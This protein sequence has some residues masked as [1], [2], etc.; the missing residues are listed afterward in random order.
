MSVP[1]PLSARTRWAVAALLAVLWFALLGDRPLRDPDEGRYAEI[2][3]E[4]VATGDWLTPR[5]NG[6]K[7]FEKPPL[8]YW[9]TATLFSAF[10]ES[11]LTA[12]LWVGLVGFF[13]GLWTWL[14]GARLFGGRAGLLSCLV[15]LSSSLYMLSGHFVTLDMTLSVFMAV[16]FGA[17]LVAQADRA[18][19]AGV[20]RW[21][22]AGW[23]ALGLAVL[24]KGPVGI[25]LPGVAVLLYMVWQ[26]DW[27]LLRHLH[28][29]VGVPV[30]LAIAAPWFVAVSIAN[31]EFPWFFFVHEH[32]ERFTTDVH[33]RDEPAYF[34]FVVLLLG[35]L[36]W[37]AA[38]TRE[39]LRP[40]FGWRGGA[41]RGFDAQRLLWVYAVVVVAFFSF[42]HSKLP[43]YILPAMP[44]LALL[45]GKGLADRSSFRAEGATLGLLAG[46][47]LLAAATANWWPPT[48]G[49]IPDEMIRGLAPWLVGAGLVLAVGAVVTGVARSSLKAGLAVAVSAMLAMQVLSR[50]FQPIQA[51]FSNEQLAN[52][53][54]PVLAPDTPV[55]NVG[56]FEPSLAFYLGRT[57]TQ[58]KQEGELSFGIG[59]EPGTFV[60]DLDEFV[61]RWRATA[62]GVAVLHVDYIEKLDLA[63]LGGRSIYRDPNR[64]VIARP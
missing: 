19:G 15:L 49:R 35:A 60:A 57:V 10:G 30:F 7:Y 28:L 55:Y 62:R 25:V 46:L 45:A 43:T 42:S 59:E 38:I 63:A 56:H 36:P 48:V 1:M 34:F 20:R 4:M 11:N 5:L 33:H 14:V 52:A 61:A 2:A 54:L 22:L 53:V 39:L 31:P 51:P 16:A 17:L 24:A 37:L 13:G 50:G 32:L 12:R 41:G 64:V 27:V 47:L 18:D 40:R 23:G 26:R 9:A 8:Q 6:F 3:R 44:A 58:V 29:R 21:M